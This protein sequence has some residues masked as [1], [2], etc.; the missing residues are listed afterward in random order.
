MGETRVSPLSPFCLWWILGG[1]CPWPLGCHLSHPSRG[2]FHLASRV[3]VGSEEQRNRVSWREGGHM[4]I[5]GVSAFPSRDDVLGKAKLE[6][7]PTTLLLLFFCI[8]TEVYTFIIISFFFN[9]E[10]FFFFFGM[11]SVGV[12]GERGWGRARAAQ[13]F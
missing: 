2:V 13:D 1:Y 5:S 11:R 12:P 10:D 9:R 6:K 7:R 3:G 8:L 4:L